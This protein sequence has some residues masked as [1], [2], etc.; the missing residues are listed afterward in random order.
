MRL[1]VGN[2]CAKYMYSL[3]AIII[4]FLYNLQLVS[5]EVFFIRCS[6]L[7]LVAKNSL[8]T[9]TI[10]VLRSLTVK[11]KIARIIYCRYVLMRQ[12]VVNNTV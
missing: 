8:R 5:Q 3:N 9:N 1:N 7:V 10:L 11:S 6:A 12:V 2:R 4:Y